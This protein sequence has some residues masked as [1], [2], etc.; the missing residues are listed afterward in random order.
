VSNYRHPNVARRELNDK[1]SAIS[2]K[3]ADPKNRL[4]DGHVRYVV[5]S[6]AKAA[7]PHRGEHYRSTP[8]A[9]HVA[10][11]RLRALLPQERL[12]KRENVVG[13]RK[14]PRKRSFSR[15][16]IKIDSLAR[17]QNETAAKR[18]RCDSL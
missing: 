8:N 1:P 2:R 14:C 7:G 9:R 4:E 13:T 12:R 15:R 10:I 17:M 6:N 3:A 5:H 18:S 11:R 16:S